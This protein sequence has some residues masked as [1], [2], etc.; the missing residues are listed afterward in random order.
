MKLV[1]GK[2]T[3]CVHTYQQSKSYM[4]CIHLEGEEKKKMFL[5]L[6]LVYWR[7]RTLN[8]NDFQVLFALL[9]TVW[10]GRIVRGQLI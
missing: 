7:L 8:I 3:I 4:C 2:A 1:V 6:P 10:K 9:G 5:K